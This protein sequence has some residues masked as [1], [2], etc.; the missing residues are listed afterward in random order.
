MQPSERT[1]QVPAKKNKHILLLSGEG[2][3][4]IPALVRSRMKFVDGQGVQMELT[5]RSKSDDVSI[6]LASAI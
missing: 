2:L 6:A 5:V 4:G 1:E 3:G